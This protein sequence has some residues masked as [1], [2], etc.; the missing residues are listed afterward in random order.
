MIGA[1][2]SVVNIPGRDLGSG[3]VV[4]LVELMGY[5]LATESI[6]VDVDGSDVHFTGL[7]AGVS[8]DVSLDYASLAYDSAVSVELYLPD[9]TLLAAGLGGRPVTVSRLIRG[10]TYAQREVIGRGYVSNPQYSSIDE[11]IR[12]G[13]RQVVL[14]DQATFP[15]SN[16]D[17]LYPVGLPESSKGQPVPWIYGSPGHFRYTV[18]ARVVDVSYTGGGPTYTRTVTLHISSNQLNADYETTAYID[19]LRTDDP[20]AVDVTVG[21]ENLASNTADGATIEISET[22]LSDV[23]SEGGTYWVNFD[24]DAPTL[25]IDT[26]GGLPTLGNAL[27]YLVG[28]LTVPIDWAAMSTA[29][30]RLD[31]FQAEFWIDDPTAKVYDWIAMVG[32]VYGFAWVTSPDGQYLLTRPGPDEFR[33]SVA[34]LVEGVDVERISEVSEPT[35]NLI[36]GYELEYGQAFAITVNLQVTTATIGAL[37]VRNT[38]HLE[39]TVPTAPSFYANVASDRAPYAQAG[40]GD[41]ERESAY[42]IADQ[43]TAQKVVA[44]QVY[45][46]GATAPSF[47]FVPLKSSVLRLRVG[48]LV[49][50][51]DEQIGRSS[52]LA[53]IAGISEDTEQTTLRLAF[54]QE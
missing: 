23:P 44:D 25:P 22:V 4:Y 53:Y 34:E 26:A 29:L 32:E 41:V 48:C 30:A 9:S 37:D 28:R 13:V 38:G 16:L 39:A 54:L 10:D 35:D 45:W 5:R 52:A 18:Q 24:T 43:A 2:R 50:Y 40:L 15:V 51:T 47:D 12:F 6:E 33:H 42:W 8:R 31:G 11:P 3:D 1:D 49:R 14:Q 19:W 46:R 27:R 21:S 7:V 36:A 20:L 17:D